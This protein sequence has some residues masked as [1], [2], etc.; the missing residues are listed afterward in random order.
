MLE[1]SGI[2]DF[3]GNLG[4]QGKLHLIDTMLCEDLLPGS[5]SSAFPKQL[6]VFLF[7]QIIIFAE[8]LKKPNQSG[9]PNYSYRSKILVSFILISFQF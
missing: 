4:V 8:T 6:R 1:A 9:P 2:Q 5:R 7:D 3:E